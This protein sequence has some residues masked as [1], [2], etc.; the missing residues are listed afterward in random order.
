MNRMASVYLRKQTIV[1]CAASFTTDGVGI[2][3][4][5][6]FLAEADSPATVL[7]ELTLKALNA[8]KTGVPH[9]TDWS[10]LPHVVASAF[11][12]KSDRAVM[13][14]KPRYCC[15]SQTDDIITAIPSKLSED[16]GGFDHLPDSKLTLP[17][18]SSPGAIGEAIMEALRRSE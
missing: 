5:P 10:T 4:G 7:G 14:G 1:F 6:A 18:N 12:L 8:S 11:G 2:E 17:A 16:G 9:P 3:S 15:I 13:S